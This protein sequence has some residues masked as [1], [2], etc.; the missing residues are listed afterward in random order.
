MFC[1]MRTTEVRVFNFL[2]FWEF[3]TQ[4]KLQRLSNYRLLSATSG[5][6]RQDGPWL[7]ASTPPSV[8]I[9]GDSLQYST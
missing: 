4:P 8:D 2:T 5:I 7:A 9:S 3:I 6:M 1:L